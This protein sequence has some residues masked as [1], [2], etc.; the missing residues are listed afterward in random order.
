MPHNTRFKSLEFQSL[1]GKLSSV[2]VELT[3]GFTSP[4]LGMTTK[5]QNKKE[6]VQFDSTLLKEVKEV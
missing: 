4:K 5:Y 3:N 1:T 6:K 2:I